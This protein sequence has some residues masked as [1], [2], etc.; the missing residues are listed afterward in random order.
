M[1]KNVQQFAGNE[2]PK[3]R[4]YGDRYNDNKTIAILVFKGV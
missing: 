1:G 4:K 3:S 2:F